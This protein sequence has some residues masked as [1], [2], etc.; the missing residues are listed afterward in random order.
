MFMA[1]YCMIFNFHPKLEMTPLTCFRS[2]LQNNLELKFI[3]VPDK[4]YPYIDH[5]DLRCFEDACNTVL[6]K[7][8]EAGHLHTLYDGM[9]M[10][11]RCLKN[12]FDSVVKIQNSELTDEEKSQFHVK[13]DCN[14]FLK[15]YSHC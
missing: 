15:E 8:K 4:F 1:S 6:E 9:Q 2:F 12:Y 13:V 3:T 11:Y 5:D 14:P 7:K 10:V